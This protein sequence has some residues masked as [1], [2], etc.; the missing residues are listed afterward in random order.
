MDINVFAKFY[1]ILSLPFQDIEKPK[2]H[3]RMDRRENSKYHP[4]P[5]PQTQFAYKKACIM[6]VLGYWVHKES[7]I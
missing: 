2:R 4:P 3:G 5:T 7:E 1:E 6:M